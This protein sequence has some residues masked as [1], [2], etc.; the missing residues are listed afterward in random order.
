MANYLDSDGLLYLKGILDARYATASQGIKAD[1][2]IQ[3]PSSK[4]NGY[5]LKFD[6]TNWVASAIPD[7]G[8][9]SVDD[10]GTTIT[11]DNTD[12]ANPVVSISTEYKSLIDNAVQSEQDKGLSSNDFTNAYKTKL[13]NAATETW[14][15]NKGYITLTDVPVQSVNGKTGAV[16]LTPADIGLGNV[17][18]LKGSKATKTQLPTTGNEQGDVWYVVDESVGYIWLNDGTTNR[19]EKLGMEVSLAGYWQGVDS[20]GSYYLTNITNSEID[21]IFADE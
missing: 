21:N 9:L 17:F 13:D 15:T 1:G 11:V 16:V 19:W 4:Q 3:N 7:T 8:V 5:F 18:K 12:P 20:T 6:G 14:V 2:A 10:D